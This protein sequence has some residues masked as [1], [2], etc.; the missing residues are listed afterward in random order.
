MRIRLQ[1]ILVLAL[2]LCESDQS[3]AISDKDTV[4]HTYSLSSTGSV[5]LNF[6][7]N[8]GLLVG[9]AGQISRAGIE[10]ADGVVGATRSSC[11]IALNATPLT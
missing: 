4:G 11:M 3:L 5:V 1:I 2:M 6:Y 10:I 9:T 7:M 8:N